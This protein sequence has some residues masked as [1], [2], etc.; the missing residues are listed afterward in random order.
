MLNTLLT[1]IL[2]HRWR[3]PPISGLVRQAKTY[4]I[5]DD[6]NDKGFPQDLVTTLAQ[7]SWL[8]RGI[9]GQAAEVNSKT[10]P[11]LAA[12][13]MRPAHRAGCTTPMRRRSRR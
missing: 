9:Q 13:R 4:T 3:I 11:A 1:D 6:K 5:E 12:R 8:A 10:N 2:N 7:L